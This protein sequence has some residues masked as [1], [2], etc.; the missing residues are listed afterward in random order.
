[1]ALALGLNYIPVP[2]P[3]RSKSLMKS[4]IDNQF[5]DY[6]R[7]VRIKA[8]FLDKPQTP[9]PEFYA[10]NRAS[11]FD[12]DATPELQNYLDHVQARLHS[13]IDANYAK[14]RTP[15]YNPVWLRS[16]L[17]ELKDN[18]D[19][20]VTNA[21]KNMGV[22]V[23]KT[24]DYISEAQ[25]QLSDRSTYKLVDKF[26]LSERW[27]SLRVI[28]IRFGF[29][30]YHDD[31]GT[32]VNHDEGSEERMIVNYLTQL[33]G[34]SELR[35]FGLFYLLMKVH[36]KIPPGSTIPPGRPIVSSINTFTYF[37]S[38]YVDKTLQP[39]YKLIESYVA[40]SQ[41]LICLL[42]Q[43]DAFPKDCVILCADIESL[44]PNIPIEQGL[45]MFR[46]SVA[47]YNT[48]YRSLHNGQPLL[49]EYDIRFL[50]AITRF[51]LTN[52][53]FTFG[54]VV[55]QQING[56]AMGTPLAVVFACFVVDF[57]E[58]T[59][60]YETKIVPLLFRRYIDD[61][62]IVM[63]TEADA[64]RF[65]EAFNRHTPSIRCPE[66]CVSSSEGIM[67]DLKIFK[68]LDF[69]RSGRFSTCIYQK[70]QNKYLY[71]PPSS[72]HSHHVFPAMVQAEIHRYRTHCSRDE[73]FASVC[74]SFYAR[75]LERGH[76]ATQLDKWFAAAFLQSREELLAKI[77][78]RYD[79]AQVAEKKD[80]PLPILFKCHFMP[81][82]KA[83]RISSCLQPVGEDLAVNSP[84]WHLTNKGQTHPI[85]CFMNTSSISTYFR[86]SRKHLHGKFS[87]DHVCELDLNGP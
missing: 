44:Y 73:D 67:L 50:V 31:T 9:M 5:A 51:V 19:I 74:K 20:I 78:Q 56:T 81:Q 43:C 53:Y 4:Y 29:F 80:K 72:F 62:F 37:A 59:I 1:M 55:Y 21:D 17:Q 13:S 65:I 66:P 49:S 47:F 26:S 28:L 79:R 32:Y 60:L 76:S 46:G 85:T 57:I 63:K 70:P 22:A 71:L 87:S 84:V 15:R 86:Q 6:D 68:G 35:P 77:R 48:K 40:S 69:S 30:R 64:W 34:C 10:P 11:T 33:Q 52:N 3:F 75:L 39:L 45:R 7:R 27:N 54:D 12:P 82:T 38:K 24:V 36:K 42:E 23:V 16:T 58:R 2:T 61:F 25:R 83:I 14:T 18:K 8:F 41:H